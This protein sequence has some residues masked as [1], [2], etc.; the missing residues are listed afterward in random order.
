MGLGAFWRDRHGRG[1]DDHDRVSA[2][3]TLRALAY[4]FAHPE[5]DSRIEEDR[6]M[7]GTLSNG[8]VS[9][10]GFRVGNDQVFWAA[11]WEADRKAGSP[12][13][14]EQERIKRIAE[15]HDRPGSR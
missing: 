5:I 3:A 9:F 8:T 14:H 11:Y 7:H 10:W 2:I 4:L 13:L 15:L 1:M 6:S 12:M